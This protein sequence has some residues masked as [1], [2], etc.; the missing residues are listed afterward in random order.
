HSQTLPCISCS[1]QGFAGF[2]PTSC[3]RLS[4]LTAYHA[5]SPRRFS[6]SPKLHVVCVPPRQAYSHC[7][8]VGSV[9]SQ[10]AGS[11][12]SRRSCSVSARQNALASSHD[13]CSTGNLSVSRPTTNSLPAPVE[14]KLLGLLCAFGLFLVTPRYSPCV[15]SYLPSQKPRVS[16]TSTPS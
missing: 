7:A 12:P 5:K 13:T 1:P 16:F 9:Y 4:E 2:R 6:E 10:P 3:V 8:S 14:A 15:A 11:R